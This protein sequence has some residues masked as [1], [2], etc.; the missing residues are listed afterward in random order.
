MNVDEYI[1]DIDDIAVERACRGETA[2][3]LN[4]AEMCAAWRI[5]EDRGLSASG[6]ATRLGVTERTVTRWRSGEAL[7]ISRGMSL[8]PTWRKPAV[9]EC[10]ECGRRMDSRHIA[11]HR[12]RNHPNEYEVAS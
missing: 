1:D 5:L 10:G 4:R 12:R 9:K 8:A 11:R 2:V 3:P 6:I 7:P